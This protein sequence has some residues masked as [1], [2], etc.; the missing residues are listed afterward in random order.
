MNIGGGVE[1]FDDRR[2]ALAE[3]PIWDHR[4]G[5][6]LWVDIASC[7]IHSRELSSG[8]WRKAATPTMVGACLPRDREGYSSCS[9]HPLLHQRRDD[10]GCFDCRDDLPGR[11]D[12]AFTSQ[13]ISLRPGDLIATGTPPGVGFAR[14]PPVFLEDGD[15]ISV[16]IEGIGTLTNPVMS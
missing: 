5:E 11:R 15:L 3:G 13:A 2:A 9:S 16:E 4:S 6:V 14:N 8:R 7:A 1:I 10:A 12:I